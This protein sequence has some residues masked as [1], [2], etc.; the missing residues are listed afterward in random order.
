MNI[1]F[2]ENSVDQQF[3]D[4]EQLLDS[5]HSY[6]LPLFTVLDKKTPLILYKSSQTIN[7]NLF[8]NKSYMEFFSNDAYKYPE[9]L[10]FKSYIQKFIDDPYI[11]TTANDGFD[12]FQFARD[13][14]LPLISFEH[15][16][17]CNS[18]IPFEQ[19]VL[20][21]F[22]SVQTYAEYLFEIKKI[23]LV[24]YLM[25]SDKYPFKI[26]FLKKNNQDY[27]LD[28]LFESNNISY[29]DFPLILKNYKVHLDLL[30]KGEMGH[31]AKSIE[32]DGQHFFEFR[33]SLMN[34]RELRIFYICQDEYL[35][36]LNG[37]VKKT[38]STPVKEKELA[39]KLLKSYQ[40]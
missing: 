16:N 40:N 23:S 8:L 21:N 32:Y 33:C 7:R 28:S 19:C 10:L 24:E 14:S 18:K 17:Y 12:C 29:S 5:L 9:L 35:V 27:I 3:I 34:N 30:N 38:E 2:N 36:Y 13:K 26:K 4:E 37:F 31:F 11:D 25:Y 20:S 15:P 1:V 22:Y 6:T 39:V